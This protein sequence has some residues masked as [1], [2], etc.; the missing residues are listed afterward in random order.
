MNVP[1][2]RSAPFRSPITSVVR[3]VCARSVLA[4]AIPFASTG[5]RA[6]HAAP[7][8]LLAILG[9]ALPV[10]AGDAPPRGTW[11][12]ELA[13]AEREHGAGLTA[14]TRATIL[15][16]G[17]APELACLRAELGERVEL[18]EF[19]RANLLRALARE[20]LEREAERAS[21]EPRPDG[22]DP[23]ALAAW[24]FLRDEVDA[25]LERIDALPADD[26]GTNAIVL[27]FLAAARR[28]VVDDE[29]VASFAAARDGARGAF[30]VLALQAELAVEA[31]AQDQR[32]MEESS[33]SAGAEV[34]YEAPAWA[35]ASH[36]SEAV[37][38]QLTRVDPEACAR[39]LAA[40]RAVPEFAVDRSEE[41]IAALEA[42]CA[43]NVLAEEPW[44]ELARWRNLRRE[45][46][47]AL[48]AIDAG[49]H[50]APA[51]A[52]GW[53]MRAVT[54]DALG[55][56]RAAL[57]AA[58]RGLELAHGDP[59][60]ERLYVGALVRLGRLD[61]ALIA[62]RELAIEDPHA[63]WPAIAEIL[64]AQH[65]TVGDRIEGWRRRIERTLR[66]PD[67]HARLWSAATLAVLAK[68]IDERARPLLEDLAR[69]PDDVQ[70]ARAA[71]T[72]LDD[73]PGV[74]L[75]SGFARLAR[76]DRA[77]AAERW[78]ADAS[79]NGVDAIA[80][81]GLLETFRGQ[82][83]WSAVRELPDF[84]TEPV[85]WLPDPSAIAVRV[86]CEARDLAR[87]LTALPEHARRI[88]LGRGTHF[89]PDAWTRSADVIGLGNATVLGHAKGAQGSVR[90][91]LPPGGSLRLA[92]LRVDTFLKVD[93]GDLLGRRIE[94]SRALWIG[95]YDRRDPIRGWFE[96]AVFHNTL[97]ID[98]EFTSARLEGCVFDNPLA[99]DEP[100]RLYLSQ[101]E[102][103]RCVVKQSVSYS[104][105]MR[106]DGKSGRLV[107]EDGRIAGHVY[108]DGK[109]RAVADV[110]DGAKARFV[111][112]R[113]VDLE[114]VANA[115]VTAEASRFQR[116]TKHQ[117]DLPGW[118]A[119]GRAPV[120]RRD[121]LAPLRV[122]G[123]HPTLSAALAAAEPGRTLQL[124]PGV[125]V[126]EGVLSRDVV[127]VGE[128]TDKTL[129]QVAQ[130][131]STLTVSG[132]HVTLRE[133]QLA[134]AGLGIVS[135]A[136]RVGLESNLAVGQ[137]EA[138]TLARVR[139]GTLALV[140][141][142]SVRDPRGIVFEAGPGGA[143][144]G[145]AGVWLVD[146]RVEARV[147]EDGVVAVEIDNELRRFVDAGGAWSGLGSKGPAVAHRPVGL[148]LERAPR[149][150]IESARVERLA[151]VDGLLQRGWPAG[152]PE[153]LADALNRVHALAPDGKRDDALFARL[154]PRFAELARVDARAGV[155]DVIA[156]ALIGVGG[157]DTIEQVFSTTRRLV[158]AFLLHVP[159]QHRVYV[160][161]RLKGMDAAQA[162]G[163]ARRVQCFEARDAGRA[164]EALALAEGL[165][166]ITRAEIVA[167]TE[168][169]KLT[170]TELDRL[171][172]A[173][174][175]TP[176]LE[177]RLRILK[178]S[179]FAGSPAGPSPLPPAWELFHHYAN[180]STTG[181][182]NKYFA[183]NE[184]TSV[185]GNRSYTTVL[186]PEYTQTAVV[187]PPEPAP[188]KPGSSEA[189]W[190]RW[191]AE[192]DAWAK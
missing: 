30:A 93:S 151:R 45:P 17:G 103:L 116:T 170:W 179:Y 187:K 147:E 18:D 26:A 163:K 78:L 38:A 180:A 101:A 13:R 140:A 79:T 105:P 119:H 87:A 160:E 63:A 11:L 99:K 39:S 80:A 173:G 61:E 133:L 186:R 189:E 23:H 124:G 176:R 138:R 28:G 90:V 183:F 188:P 161:A 145:R 31:L 129:L 69:R 120:A 97:R 76:G 153:F 82:H 56:T 191:Y 22:R 60:L 34:P 48:A 169:R 58:E 115:D 104:A 100:L 184:T 168:P 29:S 106:C 15:E 57:L 141:N 102:L 86:P 130:G 182:G 16:R 25:A 36:P 2:Q 55:D 139:D 5:F 41:A 21:R 88:V 158:Q 20:G 162:D 91:A 149:E 62:G 181:I 136:E 178:T 148:A 81:R 150:R 157:D 51:D 95:N 125:H 42:A 175:L 52:R 123:D 71:R 131:S 9:L 46:A 66:E 134:G 135:G 111:R 142:V 94:A 33:M 7:A 85:V 43:A 166:P 73:T 24:Y 75:W 109:L 64:A 164:K 132:A 172:Y 165:D 137:K 143:V 112:T 118:T 77:G 12:E 59:V 14:A 10:R 114:P 40:A 146:P 110:G 174:G 74:A 89:A 27:R 49:L 185:Y 126:V 154:E 177:R 6:L 83:D 121:D 167:T 65:G 171:L 8:M 54:S 1:S 107:V 96:D 192:L 128:H 70:L 67:E 108:S 68:R 113:I 144:L 92:E 84:A 44:F 117:T 35:Y 127:I 122:P 47:L 3:R 19:E 159:A 72:L 4:A 190:D 32:Y 53:R 155:E 98:G 152:G 156:L 50:R 37:R